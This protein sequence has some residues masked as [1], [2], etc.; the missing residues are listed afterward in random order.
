MTGEQF[1]LVFSVEHRHPDYLNDLIFPKDQ[2]K[3]HQGCPSS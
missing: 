3:Y 2:N 1:A